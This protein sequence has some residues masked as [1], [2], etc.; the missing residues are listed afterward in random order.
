MGMSKQP[1]RPVEEPHRGAHNEIG[2]RNVDE[3][4]EYDERGSQGA[5]AREPEQPNEGSQ[6]DE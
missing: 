6:P 1:S 5:G 3:E 4:A 2:Y